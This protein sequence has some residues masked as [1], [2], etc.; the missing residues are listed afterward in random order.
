[1][2]ATG[3]NMMCKLEGQMDIGGHDGMQMKRVDG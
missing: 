2:V 1:M 3:G